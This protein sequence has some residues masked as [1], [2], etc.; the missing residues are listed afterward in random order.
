[1]KPVSSYGFNI[2]QLICE[3]IGLYD[4]DPRGLTVPPDNLSGLTKLCSPANETR[5]YLRSLFLANLVDE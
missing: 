1:M 4:E 2:S 3:I 5:V